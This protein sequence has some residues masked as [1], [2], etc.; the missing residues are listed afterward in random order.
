[1]KYNS[2]ENQE[3][4]VYGYI[5]ATDEEEALNSGK[6]IDSIKRNHR[7]LIRKGFLE[8]VEVDGKRVKRFNLTELKLI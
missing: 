2:N 1:M 7:S 3:K 8:I 6:S 4:P 5:F